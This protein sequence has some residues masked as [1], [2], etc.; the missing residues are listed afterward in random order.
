MVQAVL[1]PATPK[2]A[3]SAANKQT[4]TVCSDVRVI[5]RVRE[6]VL[7]PNDRDGALRRDLA[8]ERE[9]GGDDGVAGAGHDARDEP[10]LER[11]GGGEGAR[12][13]RELGGEGRVAGELWEAR[14]RADVGG[15]PDVDFLGCGR[16]AAACALASASAVARREEGGFC[17]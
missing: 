4:R 16:A 13:E 11:L 3:A 2:R 9:R 14:E 8:R 12:G 7:R 17:D 5:P 15:E 10:E 6:Q 1:D